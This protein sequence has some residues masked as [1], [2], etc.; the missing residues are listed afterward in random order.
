VVGQFDVSPAIDR[1]DAESPLGSSPD[2]AAPRSWLLWLAPGAGVAALAALSLA[3][4]RR[5]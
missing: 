5:R 3:L 1:V 2:L 4:R